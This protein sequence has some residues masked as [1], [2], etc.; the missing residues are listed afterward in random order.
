MHDNAVSQTQV[1]GTGTGDS[2]IQGAT[3][4]E[5]QGE[6]PMGQRPRPVCVHCGADFGRAQ[7]RDRHVREKHGHRRRCPF[8]DFMWARPDKI[9]AHTMANHA[10]R[11][12]TEM[13]DELAALRGRRVIEFL[14]EH[15]H[16]LDMEATP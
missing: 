15:G 1:H 8:C 10:E 16:G 13:L 5:D 4:I 14:D 7:E 6:P 3:A 2:N 12:T 9:K 11:F